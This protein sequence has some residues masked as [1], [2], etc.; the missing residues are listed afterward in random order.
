MPVGFLQVDEARSPDPDCF[1]GALMR[2]RCGAIALASGILLAGGCGA[3]SNEEGFIAGAKVVPTKPGMEHIK[4]YGDIQR[5]EQEQARKR[6]AAK[7]S[8]P[9]KKSRVRAAS[10]P[11]AREG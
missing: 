9:S 10:P 11:R 3:Q 7:K 6:Q 2:L 4:S 1:K 8:K 5:Y